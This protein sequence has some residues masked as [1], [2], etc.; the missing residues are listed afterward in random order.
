[1]LSGVLEILSVSP[2]RLAYF[3]FCSW[4]AI[5]LSLSAR[6]SSQISLNGKPTNSFIGDM[7]GC[8]SL[9]VSILMTTSWHALKQYTF[10]S[11]YHSSYR[12]YLTFLRTTTNNSA[13]G[14]RSIFRKR[15]RARPCLQFSQG[16]HSPKA[17][18]AK[19]LVLL[20]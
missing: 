6:R 3:L 15:L 14:L 8:S 7:L 9:Y 19:H 16:R 10:L 11:R 12:E 18:I 20:E 1:M 5:K 2:V 17:T 4:I 13:P